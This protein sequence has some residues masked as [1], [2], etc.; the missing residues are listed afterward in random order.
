MSFHIKGVREN[1]SQAA[2][3]IRHNSEDRKLAIQKSQMSGGFY[4]IFN[5]MINIEQN[6][7]RMLR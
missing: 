4:S 1:L 6:K 7:V 5:I 2:D 3:L